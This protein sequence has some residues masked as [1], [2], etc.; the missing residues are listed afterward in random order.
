MDGLIVHLTGVAIANPTVGGP[1]HSSV[2]ALFSGTVA[3]ASGWS[4]STTV[5]CGNGLAH[6][7]SVASSRVEGLQEGT[8]D[9]ALAN[10]PYY[11]QLS[12]AQLFIERASV[13][14]RP[15]GRFYLVT[16]QPDAVGPVVADYFGPTQVAERRGYVILSAQRL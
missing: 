12:I 7:Q 11:A 13:L 2:H 6:F 15:G 10:P 9:V 4:R 3:G 5:S 1:T 16:R 14:L 8:F